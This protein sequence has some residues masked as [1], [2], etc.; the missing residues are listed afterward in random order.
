VSQR[1]GG[2]SVVD[3]AGHRAR[4]LVRYPKAPWFLNSTHIGNVVARLSSDGLSVDILGTT[5]AL[6][7]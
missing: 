6:T 3:L 7:A 4:I 1:G 5:R 2:G